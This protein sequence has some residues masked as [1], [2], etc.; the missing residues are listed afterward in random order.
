MDALNK[1]ESRK[2]DF[3]NIF[4]ISSDLIYLLDS[5]HCILRANDA[6]ADRLGISPEK[7]V[8][9]KCF[10]HMHKTEGPIPGCPHSQL[11]KDGLEHKA[12]VFLEQLNGWYSVTVNPLRDEQGKLFGSMVVAHD[13]HERRQMELSLTESESTLETAQQIAHL[14]SWVWDMN[15]GIVSWSKEMYRIFDISPDTFDGKPESLLKIIHPD[16]VALYTHAMQLNQSTGMVP[17]LEYRI[18][19]RDGSVHY[20]FGDGKVEYNGDGKPVK[21][22]GTVL[23]ISERKKNEL[24]IIHAK[25]QA[26]ENEIRLKVAQRASKAGTWDWDIVN[27]TFYWSDEFLDIF[28]MPKDTVAGFEAWTKAL[29]PDDVGKASGKILESIEN[30]TELINDYRIILPDQEIRWIRALGTTVYENDKPKRLIGLCLD[31]TLQKAAEKELILAKER[32]VESDRLKSAFLA[33]MSHEIRTPMNGILGFAGLLKNHGLTGKQ[34]KDYIQI[35]EKSGKRLLNLINDIIDISKIESGLMDVVLKELN[36]N[37]IIEDIFAFFKPEMERKGLKC[38]YKNALPAKEAKIQSDHNKIAA[39]LTNLVKNAI[40]FTPSGSIEFGYEKKGNWLEFFVKDT[41]LGI[42]EERKQAIFERFI[43]TDLEDKHAFEGAGLGLS[44]ARAYVEIMGGRIWVESQEGKGGSS[45]YFTIPYTVRAEKQNAVIN[46]VQ[47][48]R[49]GK[50]IQ[51]LKILIA[52]DDETSDMY[53]TL[54]VEKLSREV[55][56]AATGEEAVEICR[57]HPDLDLVL[58]DIKMPGLNG[59]ESTHQIRQFNKEII[60]IAQT[61]FGLAGDREKAM[62]AGCSDYLSKPVNEALLLSMIQKYFSR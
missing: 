14:G 35:I 44:I 10:V 51:N 21:S 45:F 9:S 26:E 25:E 54:L 27:N 6:F 40:K 46:M 30:R 8:G 19:H 36:I 58:M 23:D 41:G 5:E 7:L 37:E 15:T 34:Q 60:I 20:L 16:D 48:E 57:S 2:I 18:I 50:Q 52:E 53:M 22:V 61:A 49:I 24:A 59:Y 38:F 28:K 4:K 47:P 29:H 33:N 56:H 17:S 62:K 55:L 12:D 39:I 13:I 43:Q 11:L 32:A 31:I 3:E 42:P 1:P